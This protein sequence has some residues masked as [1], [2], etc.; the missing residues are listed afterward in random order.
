MIRIWR[1]HKS[2]AFLII[3]F[4]FY[5]GS[6]VKAQQAS[7]KKLLNQLFEQSL[8][9]MLTPEHI[10]ARR[11]AKR[12]Q[13]KAARRPVPKLISRTIPVS[14]RPGS[15]I[16]VLK[17]IPGYVVSVSIFDITGQPW[18]VEH[19]TPARDDFFQVARIEVPPANSLTIMGLTEY[20][21]ANVVVNL[22]GQSVP[23]SIQLTTV[24]PGSKKWETDNNI[25]LQIDKRGPNAATPTVGEPIP[26]SISQDTFSFVD[27]IPPVDAVKLVLTPALP[28]LDAWLYQD[29]LYIRSSDPVQWPHGDDIAPAAG[30]DLKVYKTEKSASILVLHGGHSVTVGVKEPDYLYN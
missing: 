1:Y 19:A 20:A 27:G 10:K 9:Q 15:P 28:N 5:P 6:Q 25:Y 14:L 16:P 17:V 8:E 4:L 21:H 3:L 12:D 2:F 13:E 26:S 11:K 23:L 29:S 18:S 24:D 22:K 7:D 30:G